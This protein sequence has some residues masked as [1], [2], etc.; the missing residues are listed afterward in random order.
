LLELSESS[1]KSSRDYWLIT[2]LFVLFHKGDIC[3]G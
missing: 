1:T 3:K 2:E